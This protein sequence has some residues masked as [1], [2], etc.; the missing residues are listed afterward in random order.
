M[1]SFGAL[2]FLIMIAAP[3]FAADGP[4]IIEG[5]GHFQIHTGTAGLFGAFAH[6][7]LIEAQK[8]NGCATL[9]PNALTSSSIKLTFTTASLRVLDP[10]ESVSER[11]KIQKNM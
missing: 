5:R 9:N 10:K 7:H 4:C 8:I 6:D 1:K 2:L 11:S 3:A